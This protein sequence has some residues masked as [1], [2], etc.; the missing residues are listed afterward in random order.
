MRRILGPHRQGLMDM[1][2]GNYTANDTVDDI[3]DKDDE[4]FAARAFL[5]S[6]LAIALG[7]HLAMTSD[8]WVRIHA[9]EPATKVIRQHRG[10]SE[11]VLADTAGITQIQLSEI[12]LGKQDVSVQTLNRLAN[13]LRVP[14]DVLVSANE[15]EG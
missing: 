13:V 8:Q 11:R 9:G 15:A 6:S 4:A 3:E 7:Q 10:L 14:F 12:E 2:T 1:T 5:K